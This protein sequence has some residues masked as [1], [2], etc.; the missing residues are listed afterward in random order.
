MNSEKIFSKLNEI[1]SV[2][3]FENVAYG[4]IQVENFLIDE[5]AGKAPAHFKDEIE[6]VV[7]AGGKRLRP[8]LVLITGHLG[9]YQAEKHVRGAACVEMIHTASLIHDDVIDRAD[10]RRGEYATRSLLG[11]SFAVAVGDYLFSNTFSIAAELDSIK[12]LEILAF[13]AEELSL[14]EFDGHL[15][16][17]T[18]ETTLEDYLRLISR[19]TASLFRSCCEIGAVLSGAG[20]VEIE[21]VSQYGFFLG[22]A[23]QMLDDVLDVVG[24]SEVLGKPSGS[25]L[26]EGFLTLPYLI[27]IEDGFL[28]DEIKAGA[29]GNLSESELEKILNMIKSRGY[30]E[31]ARRTALDFLK[32]A[33]EALDRVNNHF[34]VESLKDIGNYVVQRYY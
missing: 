26:K 32:K 28:V 4:M 34:V 7:K 5:V 20:P 1:L 6:R 31:E 25:D 19:K 12:V 30:A 16:R 3:D 15:F 29:R 22:M 24:K 23:F 8:L 13:A 17:R 14:G 18:G 21:A 11:D 9:D 2:K 27:A 10:R 33:V